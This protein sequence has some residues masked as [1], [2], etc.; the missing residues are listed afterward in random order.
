V[1]AIEGVRRGVGEETGEH[2]GRLQHLLMDGS[3]AQLAGDAARRRARAPDDDEITGPHE[4]RRR[5]RHHLD[6]RLATQ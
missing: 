3:G 5:R 4:P 6:I 2:A 1:S